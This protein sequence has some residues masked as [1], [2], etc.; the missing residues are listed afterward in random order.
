MGYFDTVYMFIK[1]Q[2]AFAIPLEIVFV[3]LSVIWAIYFVKKIII[4]VKQYRMYASEGKLELAKMYKCDVV[5]FVFL[6]LIDISECLYIQLYAMGSALP[7]QNLDLP[8]RPMVSNCSDWL[9]HSRIFD[10]DLIIDSPFKAVLVALAQAS[11]LFS[12]AFITCLMHFLHI[13][14]HSIPLN[15]FRFIRRFLLLTSVLSILFIITDSVPQLMLFAKFVEPL[16]DLTYFLI[17]CWYTITF[18]RTL[19]WRTGEFRVRNPKLFKSAVKSRIKFAV[20]MCSM[21]LVTSLFICTDFVINYYFIASVALFYGTC[22]LNYL[23]GVPYYQPTFMPESR[24][25]ELFA[26]YRIKFYVITVLLI[27]AWVIL[28]AQFLT[29]SVM[30]YINY[31]RSKLCIRFEL[32][33]SLKKRLLKNQT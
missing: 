22:L 29:A 21:G 16:I 17:W 31:L 15:P 13:T 30:C 24:R 12:L 14:F 11:L 20:V 3:I 19:K 5:K 27:T 26:A 9:I 4:S 33:P 18:Y 7:S 2:G 8:N 28:S 23:Y 1:I 32:N 10:F 6:L 25:E